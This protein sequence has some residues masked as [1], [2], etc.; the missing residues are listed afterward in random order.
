M[1]Q[2][3][4]NI[5]RTTKNEWAKIEVRGKDEVNHNPPNRKTTHRAIFK[6]SAGQTTDAARK[7][8]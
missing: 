6:W 1:Q 4:Q 5:L 7:R 3:I 8:I 2:T